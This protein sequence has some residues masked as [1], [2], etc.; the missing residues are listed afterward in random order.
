MAKLPD[1]ARLSTPAGAVWKSCVACGGLFPGAPEQTRCRHCV[2]AL[3]CPG[4]RCQAVHP[5]DRSP[6]I[7][8][9]EAVRIVDATG[10]AAVGCVHHAAVM[11][12]SLK[13]ARAYPGA[14]PGAAI[15]AYR[16]AQYRLPFDFPPATPERGEW[17]A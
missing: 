7:G 4:Q 10:R 14:V 6:C 11:L 9:R 17:S 15:E 8:H 13:R 5:D 1:D 3:A 16:L 2:E 12:A